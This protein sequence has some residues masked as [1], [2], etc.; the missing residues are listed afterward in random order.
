MIPQVEDWRGRL[1]SIPAYFLRRS[2]YA[3]RMRQECAR[4]MLLSIPDLAADGPQLS[5]MASALDSVTAQHVE[6]FAPLF[7][8]FGEHPAALRQPLMNLARGEIEMVRLQAEMNTYNRHAIILAA[9]PN[10][11]IRLAGWESSA[12]S[13]TLLHT[14]PFALLTYGLTGP[15]Y[16]TEIYH[17]DR[18]ELMAARIGDPITLGE[19]VSMRLARGQR[20]FYPAHVTAHRQ[21]PPDAYSI[22]LNLIVDASDEP[23]YEQQFFI[24][25]DTHRLVRC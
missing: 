21:L 10:W 7:Y 9:G 12:A 1:R 2:R 8:A 5:E 16:S 22:S 19:P 4:R 3:L 13:E 14:H 15:G 6:S 18:H 25:P 17:V 20:Y 24:A 11:V 23:P